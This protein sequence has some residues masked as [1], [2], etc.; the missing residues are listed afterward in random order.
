M[1]SH[2]SLVSAVLLAVGV[3]CVVALSRSSAQR[4]SGR[5]EQKFISPPR[6]VPLS[7]DVSGAE[8]RALDYLD[9]CSRARRRNARAQALHYLEAAKEEVRRHLKIDHPVNAQVLNM[10]GCLK[11]DDG[12]VTDALH[13]W[14]GAA[15]V[16][17]EW[18][19]TCRNLIP[20]IRDNLRL[21]S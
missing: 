3:G 21:V 12:F 19:V 13:L 5:R 8:R 9:A 20:V 10:W 6:P 18:P 2:S 15:S 16:A 1:K 4:S 11:H 17:S 7:G 14:E